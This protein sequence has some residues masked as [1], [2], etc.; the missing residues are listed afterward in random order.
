MG[1]QRACWLQ[2][3]ARFGKRWEAGAIT[4]ANAVVMM[5]TKAPCKEQEGC[6]NRQRQRGCCD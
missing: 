3:G 5:Q 2:R 1:W 6:R 4:G